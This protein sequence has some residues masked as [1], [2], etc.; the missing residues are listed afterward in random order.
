MGGVQILFAVLWREI[1]QVMAVAASS[2]LF[3]SVV[4]YTQIT[5]WAAVDSANNLVLSQ[6]F[7]T[8]PS[9]TLGI[10]RVLQGLL[11]A[12][13]SFALIRSFTYIYWILISRQNGLSYL[14]FLALAPSTLTLG[15]FE[16]ILS[17]AS[18]LSTRVM[19]FSRFVSAPG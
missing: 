11:A 17:S 2:G 19:A 5:N 10:V 15:K 8:D 4:V 7:R 3:A 16:I 14:S 1:W 6:N 18:R 13:S 12:I 9:T